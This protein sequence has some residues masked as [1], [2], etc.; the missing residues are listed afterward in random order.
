MSPS[1]WT[2]FPPPTQHHPSCL[3]Q[4]PGLSFLSH[5]ENSH[6]L[7]LWISPHS[8]GAFSLCWLFP[9][10]CRSFLVWGSLT[11]LFLLMLPVLLVSYPGY[12]CQDLCHEDFCLCFLLGF[13]QFQVLSF[14]FNLFWVDFC[15]WCVFF[16][17]SFLFFFLH[18]E[19]QFYLHHLLKR[20]SFPLCDLVEDQLTIYV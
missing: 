8:L 13:L 9:L 20:L 19:I 18:V 11:C 5:T 15:I 4:S 2:S 12:Y 14:S 1:S 3:S 17:L 7:G 10:L 6:C 16:F